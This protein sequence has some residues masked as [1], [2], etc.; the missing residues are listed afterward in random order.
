[1]K[2]K[3]KNYTQLHIL[4]PFV[5]LALC[6]GI[7][8]IA[9]IKPADKLKV[10]LNLAFMDDL[11]TVPDSAD[12]G[13]VIRD[14]EIVTEHDGETS[15]TGE[16]I[17]PVFGEM[18]AIIKCDV[19]G[20]D[21]PV[22]WGSSSE[23][24]EKG[25]CQASGSVLIGDSGNSVISAHEDTYFASLKSLEEGDIITVNTN[26]GEFIYRVKELITFDKTNTKY[27]AASE[28]TKL[29]LYT[30]QKDV[31]GTSDMRI[32]VICELTEKKFYTAAGEGSN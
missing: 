30:C 21:V 23:L 9:M 28:E 6:L 11:K 7:F 31:L 32:G 1:M 20:V 24:F 27:V 4:T 17:R 16:F 2:N 26:Y 12:S 18:Y 3:E 25:A 14:N 5:V 10:Y 13:L 22:Y 29:T 8:M 15:E 19:F